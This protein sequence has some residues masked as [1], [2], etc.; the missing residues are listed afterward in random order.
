MKNATGIVAI[1][2]NLQSDDAPMP[3][4]RVGEKY[5]DAVR[6][7]AGAMPILIPA[8]AGIE[9]I[10]RLLEGVDG[11]LLTGGASNVEP[12]HYGGDPSVE[13]GPHDPGRDAVALALARAAVEQGVPL[14]GICRGHQEINVAFGGSLFPW[15][16]QVEGRFDHR[17]PR[18]KPLE[19]Q[20]SP[21]QRIAIA[22]GSY[23]QELAGGAGEFM[24]NTL[25]G[26][27][28]DRLGDGLVVEAWADDGTIE[29]I[30][31]A[32]A[33]TFAMGVQWHPEW[34]PHEH[35]LYGA[36]FAAFGAAVRERANRRLAGGNAMAAE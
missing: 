13:C 4:H 28:I 5:V 36:L 34:K 19:F 32:D 26:Q 7:A 24:V 14:F 18:D 1:T 11:V 16:H 29:A 15:L 31:V 12:H 35:A 6:H 22:E 10:G 21:R 25:H 17:R 27:G 30:R 8:L 33:V 20:L 2:C 23:L 3:S 9:E